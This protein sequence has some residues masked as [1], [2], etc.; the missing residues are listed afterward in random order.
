MKIHLILICFLPL[1]ISAQDITGVWTGYIKT[2]G[3][4]LNCEL[5]ISESNKKLS[6][7]SLI[8]YVD[9]G[10][11]NI[12]IKAAKVKQKK[13]EVSFEDGELVYDN[14]S[15]RPVRSKMFGTMLLHVKD[16]QMIMSGVFGTRSLDMR[17]ERT[18]NGEIFLQKD[19]NQASTK[20]INKLEQLNLLHTLSF[21]NMKPKKK[22]TV[23]KPVKDSLIVK[24]NVNVPIENAK[25]KPRVAAPRKTEKIRDI[26]FSA[27]SLVISIFDNGTVDGD[28][29]SLVLNGNVIVDRV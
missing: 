12:G 28:T 5:A 7:Y 20:M 18:Y 29:V 11:E 27:D 26:F 6:G 1:F 23:N 19:P 24:N 21:L 17:D 4:Q 22:N 15:S 3:S 14:F 9:D 10:I 2:P 8:V 16:S 13:R 25:P